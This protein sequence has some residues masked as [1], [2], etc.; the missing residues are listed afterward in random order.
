MNLFKTQS[1]STEA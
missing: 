1:L